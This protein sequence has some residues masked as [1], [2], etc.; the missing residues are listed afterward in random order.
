[1]TRPHAAVIALISLFLAACGKAAPS[2]SAEPVAAA[3]APPPRRAA[4]VVQ[5]VQLQDSGL[6]LVVYAGDSEVGFGQPMKA[7]I[8]AL[9]GQL[10][11]GSK[12]ELNSE[13]GA[14]PITFVKWPDDLSGLFQD[15]KFVGWSL[16]RDSPKGVYVTDKAIGIGSTR[17]EL[18]AAYPAAKVETST[19]GD[20]FTVGD[21]DGILSGKTATAHVEALWAGTSCVFR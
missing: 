15:G 10:G 17:A 14:G 2:A 20:E 8:A 6:K 11:P 5:G 12:P 7:V 1:M 4:A 19:L 13:C 18:L 9:D 3:P 16:G 21:Y